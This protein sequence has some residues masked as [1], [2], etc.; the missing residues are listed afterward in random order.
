MKVIKNLSIL[1]LTCSS[2]SGLW[3]PFLTLYKKYCHLENDLY[4]CTDVATADQLAK[5]TEISRANNHIHFLMYNELSNLSKYGNFY[6]RIQYYLAK[7]KSDNILLFIDDMFI[8]ST[9]DIDYL[10][11]LNNLLDDT[12]PIIKLSKSSHLGKYSTSYQIA[13]LCFSK[14]D[15]FKDDYI[16]N[17]QPFIITNRF[18]NEYLDFCETNHVKYNITHM[19]GG[20][21]L[22]SKHYFKQHPNLVILRVKDEAISTYCG[23]YGICQNGVVSKENQAML[24]RNEGIVI[25][26]NKGR[27]IFE[28]ITDDELKRFGFQ[29]AYRLL[30]EIQ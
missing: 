8:S 20:L 18:F 3:D 19:N 17:V 11:K 21:K 10:S 6:K 1:Y 26:L 9:V 25:E 7:I 2:F 15:P 23:E 27:F 16:F 4:I 28:T 24:L 12:I 5:L 14:N 30:N 29:N 22:L 13:D